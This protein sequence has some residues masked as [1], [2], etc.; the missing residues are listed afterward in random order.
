MN[1]VTFHFLLQQKIIQLSI[2]TFLFRT[3]I[4]SKHFQFQ[5]T[6]IPILKDRTT[7]YK[8]AFNADTLHVKSYFIFSVKR[9]VF[10]WDKN[11]I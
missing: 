5:F 8:L 11:D 4:M 3:L 2:F 6:T 1:T 10:V 9:T 7:F